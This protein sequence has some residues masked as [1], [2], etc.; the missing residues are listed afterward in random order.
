LTAKTCLLARTFSQ[1]D[2]YGIFTASQ[3]ADGHGHTQNQ[4]T[5][6]SRK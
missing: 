5:R 4:G 1:R 6:N 3:K 2:L